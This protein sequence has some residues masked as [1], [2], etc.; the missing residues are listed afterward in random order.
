M[1]LPWRQAGIETQG[2]I[3]RKR[4]KITGAYHEIWQGKGSEE[5]ENMADGSIVTEQVMEKGEREGKYLS[6]S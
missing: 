5:D 3:C 4:R 6:S 2:A 1:R